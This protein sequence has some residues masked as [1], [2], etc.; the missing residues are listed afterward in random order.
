MVS[1]VYLEQ[2]Q[3]VADKEKLYLLNTTTIMI[4]IMLEV[5]LLKYILVRN[6]SMKKEIGLMRK[7]F[8]CP[9]ILFILLQLLKK[10]MQ[11]N[12]EQQVN[13]QVFYRLKQNK[14]LGTDIHIYI[15]KSQKGWSRKISEPVFY[16]YLIFCHSSIVKRE[17]K[18]I[19]IGSCYLSCN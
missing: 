18:T 4:L 12:F 11:T 8:S 15:G 6:L 2:I 19:C 9:K 13:S 5:I 17:L 7:F 3:Q 1:N 10:R 14:I 16:I